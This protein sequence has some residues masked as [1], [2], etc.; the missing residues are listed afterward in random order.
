MK[1]DKI[2]TQIWLKFPELDINNKN[3]RLDVFL[4]NAITHDWELMELK[5]A[6]IKLTKTVRDIP[7]FVNAVHEGIQQIR[8]YK[9]ILNQDNVKKIFA[10][11]GIEYY[12][13]EYR[14]VI[15]RNPDIPL[16]QW[17]HLK[18]SNE[19]GLKI[20][21]YDEIIDSLKYGLMIQNENYPTITNQRTLLSF[22]EN[23]M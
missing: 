20:I 19:N 14:L 1:Y 15:G 11:Q 12:E 13:P 10:S 23:Q 9:R 2:E 3:R 5:K 21:T 16:E 17:R 4:R 6:D 18:K 8:N 7:V 22:P